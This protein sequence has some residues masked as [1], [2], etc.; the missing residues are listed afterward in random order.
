MGLWRSS[1]DISW[2]RRCQC[3]EIPVTSRLTQY[4]GSILDH[5]LRYFRLLHST[6]SSVALCHRMYPPRDRWDDH[7][8]LLSECTHRHSRC[9]HDRPCD[10][11]LSTLETLSRSAHRCICH[12]RSLGRVYRRSIFWES[13]GDHRESRIDEWTQ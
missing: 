9:L 2:Y 12:T 8:Y 11:S 10:E 7:L 5:I 6:L 4:D 3:E 1:S 13:D